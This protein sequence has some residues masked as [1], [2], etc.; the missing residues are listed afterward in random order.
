MDLKEA[1]P[2]KTLVRRAYHRCFSEELSR[3]LTEA[4]SKH[5][6]NEIFEHTGLV[7]GWKSLKN[8]SRFVVGELPAENINPSVATLDTLA[9][10]V[11]GAPKTQENHRKQTNQFSY[12]YRF[13]EENSEGA[14]PVVTGQLVHTRTKA[15]R[16]VVSILL[17]GLAGMAL[18]LWLPHRQAADYAEQFTDSS[19]KYLH[20]KGWLL[21]DE[22]PFYWSK[23]TISGNQLTL[24]TL[25][26]DNYPTEGQPS[27][28]RNLLLRPI[29]SDCFSAEINLDH[30]IPDKNWQQAGLLLMEDSSYASKSVRISIAYNDFF[31]GLDQPGEII[32]QILAAV[33]PSHRKPEEIAHVPLFSYA[34]GSRPFIERN[35]RKSA[36]RI[37]RRE[38]VYRF[39]YSTGD[40]SIFAFKEI[41]KREIDFN[42]KFVAIFASSGETATPVIVPVAVDS[43]YI[44]AACK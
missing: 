10:F 38:N 1:E 29:D 4:E 2:F 33:L 22:A 14:A 44:N 16:T 24:Y 17:V 26:G 11:A 23:H 42:P 39:S 40:S 5:V 12:W 41:A 31:G 30:F 6:S 32:I 8:Y 27:G 15:T 34:T 37:E 3:M 18:F 35:L 13:R 21:K 7:I 36:L 19:T 25:S 20:S 28:I 9:R 43:F